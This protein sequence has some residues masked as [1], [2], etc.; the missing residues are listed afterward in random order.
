MHDINTLNRLN[1]ES[2]GKAILGWQNEGRHVVAVYEGLTLVSATPYDTHADAF[3][4]ASSVRAVAGA[5]VVLIEPHPPERRI[6]ERDQSEDTGASYASVEDYLA[7][8]A[9]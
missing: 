7:A 3:A 2:H 9:V 1:A 8:V 5:R 4:A 6:G